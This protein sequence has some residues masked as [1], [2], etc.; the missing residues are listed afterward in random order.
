MS[1]PVSRCMRNS[2][3]HTL[4]RLC[5]S[6]RFPLVHARREGS[7]YS[8]PPLPLCFGS[9]VGVVHPFSS[10]VPVS[11]FRPHSFL[12]ELYSHPGCWVLFWVFCFSPSFSC[13]FELKARCMWHQR[14]SAKEI[15]THRLCVSSGGPY[16]WP[17]RMNRCMGVCVCVCVLRG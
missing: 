7:V 5:P 15:I 12:R 14:G 13:C 3:P 1:R 11:C 2:S 6:L 8:R 10:S 16:E 4:W 9:A 17:G